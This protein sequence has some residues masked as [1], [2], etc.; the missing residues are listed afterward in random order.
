MLVNKIG[1]FSS[2][3]LLEENLKIKYL[4]KLEIL[5]NLCINK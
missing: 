3:R 5:P 4:R 1:R 2:K